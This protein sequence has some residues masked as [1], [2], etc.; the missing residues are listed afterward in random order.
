MREVQVPQHCKWYQVN[1]NLNLTCCKDKKR[2]IIYY[3]MVCKEY[4]EEKDV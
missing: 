2:C 1:Q 3:E 4:K